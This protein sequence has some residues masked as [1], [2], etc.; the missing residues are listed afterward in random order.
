MRPKLLI[1]ALDGST[2]QHGGG[3]EVEDPQK[4][5]I[6]VTKLDIRIELAAHNAG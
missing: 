1:H 6:H 2:R 5:I 3:E 4:M